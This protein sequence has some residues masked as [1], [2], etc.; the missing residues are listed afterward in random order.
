[1]GHRTHAATVTMF[2]LRQTTQSGICATLR[3]C[4]YRSGWRA[5]LGFT[6]ERSP[7]DHAY[8]GGSAGPHMDRLGRFRQGV[9]FY[10]S[11]LAHWSETLPVHRYMSIHRVVSMHS[12]SC[13]PERLCHG[14]GTERRAERLSRI[15]RSPSAFVTHRAELY[16]ARMAFAARTRRLS[17]PCSPPSYPLLIGRYHLAIHAGALP[18]RGVP[19]CVAQPVLRPL[20]HGLVLGWVDGSRQGPITP[21]PKSGIT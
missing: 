9:H 18:K 10:M 15:T 17:T 6:A 12:V 4:S 14:V 8:V 21:W 16:R 7:E 1:M 19:A 13:M 20:A 2:E 5:G 11:R 3:S